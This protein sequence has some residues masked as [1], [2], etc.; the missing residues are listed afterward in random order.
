MQNFQIV[1]PCCGSARLIL[2]RGKAVSSWLFE[3]QRAFLDI[4]GPALF[5][6]FGVDDGVPPLFLEMWGHYRLYALY[7]LRYRHGQHTEAQV[8]EAQGHLFRYAQLAE[9]HLGGKLLTL[10][11]HRAVVHIP[12]QALQLGPSAWFDE[13]WG[14]RDIRRPKSFITN[15]STRNPEKHAANVCLTELGL[16]LCK[17]EMPE[18]AA[19]ITLPGVEQAPGICDETAAD[20]VCLIGRLKDANERK[21]GDQ[22]R[23]RA[24]PRTWEVRGAWC[25][26]SAHSSDGSSALTMATPCSTWPRVPTEYTAMLRVADSCRWTPSRT[27]STPCSRRTSKAVTASTT[28][29]Q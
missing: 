22:V 10:C 17:L 5:S 14:E 11:L 13:S 26:V 15:H 19:P 9:R 24:R 25:F 2:C 4:V 23:Q 21:T 18:I 8:R 12:E 16:E 29:L 6:E 28:P 7:F 3:E 27:P 1:H 20:G